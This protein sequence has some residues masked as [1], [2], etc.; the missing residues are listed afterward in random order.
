MLNDLKKYGSC[1]LSYLTLFKNLKIFTFSES[2]GY[3]AYKEFMSSVSILGDLI[4]PLDQADNAIK[5][6]ISF[7]SN[8]NKHISFFLCTKRN[9]NL[10][11]NNGFKV[12]YFGSEAVVDLYDFTISGNKNWKIRSSINYARKKNLIVEEYNFNGKRDPYIEDEISRISE[13]WKKT[14]GEPELN[15][16]FGML[17][18]DYLKD[19]R[20]FICK[21]NGSIVGFITLYPIFGLNSYYLDLSRRDHTAPRGVIDLLFVE[22]FN[23]LR[24]EGVNKVYIGF[25]PL[26]FLDNGLSVNSERYITFLR[27]IYPLF[28]MLYPTRSEL[29]FKSKYASYWEPNYICFYPRISIR[30]LFCLLH[31]IYEGGFAGLLSYKINH[32]FQKMLIHLKTKSDV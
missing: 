25:S 12:L 27:K 22:S 24:N 19:S 10:L 5:E 7:C 20:Y 17:D 14:K 1:S 3:F 13:E 8:T 32:F 6:M 2:D 23:V 18:F 21:D 26:S 30:S 9:V 31:S 4:V 29:F 16:A 11:M 28:H 15:F